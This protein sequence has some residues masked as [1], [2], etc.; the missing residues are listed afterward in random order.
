VPLPP[1]PDACWSEPPDLEGYL[2]TSEVLYDFGVWSETADDFFLE[3]NGAITR[4]RWWGGYYNTVV[5]CDPGMTPS[6]F[7]L[8]FYLSNDDDCLPATLPGDT[9]VEVLVGGMAGEASIGC[10]VSG[11]PLYRYETPVDV[12]LFGA[13]RYWFSAQVADHDFPPQWGRLTAGAVIG[14]EGVFSSWYPFWMPLGDVAGIPL[15][16]SQEFECDEP[17]AVQDRSWGAI[18]RLYR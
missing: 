17:V 13:T 7:Y 9:Y 14:C 8:R 16:L 18:K 12:P 11:N 1:N 5:P 15:D 4:V 2:I 3:D 10:Q 6:G